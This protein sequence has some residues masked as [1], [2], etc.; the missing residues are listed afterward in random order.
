[1]LVQQVLLL[2]KGNGFHRKH[3]LI[4]TTFILSFYSSIVFETKTVFIPEKIT[5]FGL[6]PE[7]DIIS[8]KFD[9]DDGKLFV[10]NGRPTKSFKPI[11]GWEY[12]LSRI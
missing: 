7:L 3:D 10:Q 5:N 12:C 8:D 9:N 1:M 4:A 11:S 6:K 2:I